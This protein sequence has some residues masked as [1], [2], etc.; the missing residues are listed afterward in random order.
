M[1]RIFEEREEFD[2]SRVARTITG[3]MIRRHP[4]VFGETEVNSNAE[5]V[6][7]WHKIKLSEKKD[8]KKQ[9]SVPAKLPALMR[10]YRISDRAANSGFEITETD[11]N[12]KDPGVVAAGLQAA[13]KNHESRLAS[14]HIG[15]LIFALVNIARLAEIHPENALAGSVRIFE[16]RINKAE[17]LIS[18]AHQKIDEIS[19]DQKKRIWQKVQKIIP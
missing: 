16:A 12:Q 9:Y 5:V 15:D 19:L 1:A 7:N 4:H 8:R 14:R 18:E 3:K 6:E 17:E 13:L 11:E 10:A 2:L